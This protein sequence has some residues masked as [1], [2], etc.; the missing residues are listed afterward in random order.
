[1]NNN[2]EVLKNEVVE[3]IESKL[4]TNEKAVI[5]YINTLLEKFGSKLTVRK[6]MSVKSFRILLTNSSSAENFKELISKID[7]NKCFEIEDLEGLKEAEEFNEEYYG[8]G[9]EEYKQ[10]KAWLDSRIKL[11]DNLFMIEFK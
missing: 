2:F 9:T 7:I 1:M 4:S 10:Y 5:N 11:N 8:E 6:N 3:L